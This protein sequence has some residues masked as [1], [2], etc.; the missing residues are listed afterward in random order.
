MKDISVDTHVCKKSVA[1]SMN[2]EFINIYFSHDLAGISFDNCYIL[3][4]K[5]ES[6][7]DLGVGCSLSCVLADKYSGISL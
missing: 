2:F 1:F 3:P 5:G 6:P 4:H 7:K